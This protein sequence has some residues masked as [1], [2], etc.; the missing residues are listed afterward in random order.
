MGIHK[1]IVIFM[2][3]NT[4]LLL[5]RMNRIYLNKHNV[6]NK[7]LRVSS[8]QQNMYNDTIV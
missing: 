4:I 7:I 8:G 5:K 1:S 2:G 6:K 3:R